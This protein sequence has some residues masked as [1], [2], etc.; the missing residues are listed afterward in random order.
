M[1]KINRNIAKTHSKGLIKIEKRI[2]F[3]KYKMN[4]TLQEII[5][6]LKIPLKSEIPIN[7][8]HELEDILEYSSD[9]FMS[10]KELAVAYVE[11][12]INKNSLSDYDTEIVEYYISAWYDD[13][14][15]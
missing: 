9:D 5:E 2:V 1:S 6:A 4:Y 13:Y 11:A 14:L 3:E 12:W 7:F 15:D 10:K 8:Q